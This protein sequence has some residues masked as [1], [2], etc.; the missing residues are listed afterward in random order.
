MFF[1]FC[2]CATQMFSVI[3]HPR[4]FS[5]GKENKMRFCEI[6]DSGYGLQ[7]IRLCDGASF[8]MQGDDAARFR[9]E[10]QGANPKWSLGQFVYQMGYDI[11][12][13]D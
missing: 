13:A 3:A 7:V 2:S 4:I 9:Y 10:W 12:F 5:N 6:L 11:L 1:E 8:W